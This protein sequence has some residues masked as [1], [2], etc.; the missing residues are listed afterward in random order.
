M[1]KIMDNEITKEELLEERL[2]KTEEDLAQTRKTLNDLLEYLNRV[3]DQFKRDP[4]NFSDWRQRLHDLREA[5]RIKKECDAAKQL[6]ERH[7]YVVAADKNEL[8]A[9][10]LRKWVKQKD[11]DIPF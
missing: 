2:I 3:D 1:G 6:L 9:A 4:S 11:D 7:G 5:D 10:R 8:D